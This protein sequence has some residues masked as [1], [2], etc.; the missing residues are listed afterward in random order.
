MFDYLYHRYF[1]KRDNTKLTTA[2][3][4]ETENLGFSKIFK[5]ISFALLAGHYFG[6]DI[7]V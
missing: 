7:V 2:E 3:N 1:I 4:T 5:E 6:R